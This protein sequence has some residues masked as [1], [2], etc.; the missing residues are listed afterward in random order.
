MAI[1]RSAQARCHGVR[2]HDI[3]HASA[4]SAQAGLRDHRAFVR[5][6]YT[7]RIEL[8]LLYPVACAVLIAYAPARR[9][10]YP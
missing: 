4:S 7:P 8:P 1:P 3:A 6:P 5:C 10:P 2:I 9:S